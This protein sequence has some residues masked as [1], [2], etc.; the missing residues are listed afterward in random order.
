M[1]GFLDL[2]L[3]LLLDILLFFFQAR[4]KWGL[5]FYFPTGEFCL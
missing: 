4:V 3:S 1:Q 2:L 5:H